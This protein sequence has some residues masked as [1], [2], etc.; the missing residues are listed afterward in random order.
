MAIYFADTSFWVALIDRHDQYHPKAVEFSRS[1]SGQII[2]TEPVLLETANTFS[3]QIWRG[4]VMAFVNQIIARDDIE[5]VPLS[6]EFWTRGWQ[7]FCER[8]DKSWSLTDCISFGVM[9]ERGLTVALAADS[10]FRQ[11]GYQALLLDT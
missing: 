9:E 6:N 11:A 8:T 2:T 1:I 10:H 3:R 5:V 7:L 4:R